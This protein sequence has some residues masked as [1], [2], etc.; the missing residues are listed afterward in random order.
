MIQP[1]LI[2]SSEIG[3]AYEG[4]LVLVDDVVVSNPDLEEDDGQFAGEWEFSDGFGSVRCGVK[5]DYFYY[6]EQG[7]ELVYIEGVIDFNW[8]NYKLNPRLAR[9]VVEGGVTRIQR[10]QQVLYSDLMKVGEDALSDTSY[11]VGDTV[12][13]RGV[14]TFP[15]GLGYAGA[16]VKFIFSDVNGGPWSSILS[17][18]PDASAF[19]VLA[20]G[21]LVEVTGYI[22]EYN[23]GNT[24]NVTEIF[25]TEPI[26]WIDFVDEMPQRNLVSTGDLNW[27]TE[28]EQWGSVIVRIENG[29]V[30]E[31]DLEYDVFEV[32]DGSGPILVDDDSDSIRVY[33]ELIDSPP[34]GTVYES[35][36]GWVYH[37]YGTYEDS[38]TYNLIPIYVEDLNLGSGP[39]VIYDV[40]R[41]PC[42]P[43]TEDNS[44]QISCSIS[45]NSL[46]TEA[47]I[48]YSIDGGEYATVSM[49]LVD[50]E[51]F[52]GELPFEGSTASSVV[53][54]ITAMDD[55][56]DQDESMSNSYPVNINQDQLGFYITDNLTIRDVQETPWP[57][58][59]SLYEDCFVTLTGVVTADTEQYDNSYR[60]YAFQDGAGQWSGMTFGSVNPLDVTRGNQITISGRVTDRN[61]GSKFRGSTRLEDTIDLIVNSEI[62]EPAPVLS[63]CEDLHQIGEEVETYE[64]V[65]VRLNN[66][67][68]SEIN[69][70]DVRITDGTGFEV[71]VDDDMMYT[72]LEL[73]DQDPFLGQF[74]VGQ[75]LDYISGIF[76]YSYG[77]Y[78]VQTRDFDDIGGVV[79]ANDDIQVNPY[80]FALYDNFPNPFNPETYIRFS[81]GQRENVKLIIYD[82]MGRRVRTLL[83]NDSFSA[84]FH[85][86]LWNGLDSK[87]QKV[88][89]GVYIYRIK[90]GNFIADNKMLLVK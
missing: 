74:Q 47:L 69:Q 33:F 86:V 11:M 2:T 4:C 45:D 40:E 54:Y 24:S 88:P 76:N 35:I 80:D 57:S 63:T 87:G 17:Y 38:N 25:I 71:L 7:Q 58:G 68:I 8:S 82:M 42:A 85:S 53:Y 77:T 61:I 10:V 29:T 12:T 41:Q 27:P 75:E 6:P 62:E 14:V 72:S 37:H 90:A 13:L 1:S 89:S 16:G 3:E 22:F 39:P 46:V 34:I 20:E 26:N 9:D 73:Q 81:I 18:D 78:K 28:A 21:D 44:V 64:G 48:H 52:V 70:Y 36:E 50:D 15:T 83:S 84:G 55:G 51:T 23:T 59:N 60:S 67:T 66:V 5:W 79:A 31:T 43:T 65:L 30:T 19:P 32:D 56:L 49:S